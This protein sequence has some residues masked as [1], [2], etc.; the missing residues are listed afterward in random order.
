[1]LFDGLHA[2]QPDAQ[3]I[4]VAAQDAPRVPPL[5]SLRQGGQVRRAA[6]VVAHGCVPC[7]GDGVGS[8]S[9]GNRPGVL[10]A[11][12]QNFGGL[13]RRPADRLRRLQFPGQVLARSSPSEAS[14]GAGSEGRES[15]LPCQARNRCA[16]LAL[17][18]LAEPP[19]HDAPVPQV[20]RGGRHQIQM[21]AAQFL[22]L[23]RDRTQELIGLRHRLQGHD[24]QE[25]PAAGRSE[26]H[27][28]ETEFAQQGARQNL[29]QQRDPARA[30][31]QEGFGRLG[32]AASTPGAGA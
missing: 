17:H 10:A 25:L 3:V 27:L 16:A 14:I 5:G 29:A 26:Q 24:D 4:H 9:A 28:R 30:A 13:F 15:A 7:Q 8:G 11:I 23:A 6:P 21:A 31:G 1:M 2:P 20:F 32:S 22:D 12:E 19:A 18:R